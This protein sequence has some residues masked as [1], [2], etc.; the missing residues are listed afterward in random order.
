[1]RRHLVPG[2]LPPP[3][4]EHLVPGALPKNIN[5]LTFLLTFFTY[6]LFFVVL[7]WIVG[8][9]W[10][11]EYFLVVIPWMYFWYTFPSTFYFLS[12]W[13]HAEEFSFG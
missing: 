7:F 6:L 2:A 3:W 1:M 13:V 4:A 9:R 11:F 12:L 10:S 8:F 5:K